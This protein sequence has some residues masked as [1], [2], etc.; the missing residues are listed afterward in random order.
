M[1]V[2]INGERQV[3]A[4]P[5]RVYA[6]LTDPEVVMKSVPLVQR[7]EVKDADHWD[8][9]VKVPMP[10]APALT[11]SFEVVERRA[12]EHAKLRAG[13]GGMVGGADVVSTFD[14][15]EQAGGTLV[16]FHVELTFRGA[17][18]GLER[19]LEPVARR[20]SEKTLDAIEEHA[21]GAERQR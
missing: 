4:P 17:L 16:R 3:D 18:A 6:A 8:V 5:E 1:T 7:L 10:L 12:P 9:V 19:M 11:L 13:G 20:Q 2:R 14:L 15:T 21:G